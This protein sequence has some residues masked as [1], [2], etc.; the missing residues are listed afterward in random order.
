MIWVGEQED[1]LIGALAKQMADRI[2]R[3]KIG[4][5]PIEELAA[6]ATSAV[7]QDIGEP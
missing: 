5:R 2:D 7:R 1:E 4:L 3:A 6:I